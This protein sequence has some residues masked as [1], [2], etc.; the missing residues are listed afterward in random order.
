VRTYAPEMPV[1][2]RPQAKAPDEGTGPALVGLAP[3]GS[4]PA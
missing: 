2:L 1:T 4:S 3:D